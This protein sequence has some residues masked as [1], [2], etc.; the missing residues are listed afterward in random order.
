MDP[1]FKLPMVA[2]PLAE[3]NH[4][5]RIAALR[6]RTLWACTPE[7]LSILWV[8]MEDL[9]AILEARVA[10][11]CGKCSPAPAPAYPAPFLPTSP[12]PQVPC[13]PATTP[14]VPCVPVSFAPTSQP[15]MPVVPAEI[16]TSPRSDECCA[17]PVD[18]PSPG[19]STSTDFEITDFGTTSFGDSL[20][21]TP[22]ESEVG[23][24]AETPYGLQDLPMP[25]VVKN[26]FIEVKCHNDC[27][28]D[29][30]F[31]ARQVRSCPCTPTQRCEEA[32][33]ET[34]S[35]GLL[36]AAAERLKCHKGSGAVVLSCKALPTGSADVPLPRF[37]AVEAS[38]AGSADVP[39]P[40]F[41]TVQANDAHPQVYLQEFQQD[42]PQVE[43]GQHQVFLSNFQQDSQQDSQQ[44]PPSL[45]PVAA[46]SV[47]KAE[48]VPVLRLAD[49]LGGLSDPLPS[50]GSADHRFGTCKPC[51]FL[52]TKGC[53]T[54]KDCKFCHLCKAGSAKRRKKEHRLSLAAMGCQRPAAGGSRVGI[55]PSVMEIRPIEIRP[56]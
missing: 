34:D 35:L 55:V 43:E 22:C 52:H 53:K 31:K 42:A 2:P 23:A 28:V 38:P 51:A 45:M 25:V 19:G 15:T 3:D 49:V 48:L 27:L 14:V 46:P 40:A 39:L 24:V 9:R 17:A 26:T 56:R 32:I 47:S 18:W 12:L 4:S 10:A 6:E 41:A 16:W 13:A 44:G 50:L 33:T 54:G 20:V 8:E 5:L 36:T 30:F 37:G 11:A 21:S 29:G 1:S 7:E